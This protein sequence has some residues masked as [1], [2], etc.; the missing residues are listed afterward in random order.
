MVV[1]HTTCFQLFPLFLVPVGWFWRAWCPFQSHAFFKRIILLVEKQIYMKKKKLN[2]RYPRN[3]CITAK[4]LFVK[5]DGSRYGDFSKYISW[6]PNWTRIHIK[7]SAGSINCTPKKSYPFY[8]LWKLDK[9][10][11]TYG[12]PLDNLSFLKENKS[13]VRAPQEKLNFNNVEKNYTFNS[14]LKMLKNI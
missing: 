12:R 14:I 2:S 11:W 8:I 6:S 9:T 7:L 5:V 13:C 4:Y 10:S 1:G 3:V